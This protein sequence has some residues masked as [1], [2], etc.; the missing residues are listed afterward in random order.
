MKMRMNTQ[1]TIRKQLAWIIMSE[2][3]KRRYSFVEAAKFL[4]ITTRAYSFVDLGRTKA[5][6]CN[7]KKLLDHF[8]ID[9]QVKLID[10]QKE[11]QQ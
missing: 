1:K 3:F 9:I 10:I 4:N 2:R 6:W 11:E 8:N 7:F 5:G